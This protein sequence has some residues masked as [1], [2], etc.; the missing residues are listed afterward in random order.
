MY[1]N[2][3]LIQVVRGYHDVIKNPSIDEKDKIMV[4]REQQDKDKNHKC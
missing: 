2:N 4:K 1:M 3:S